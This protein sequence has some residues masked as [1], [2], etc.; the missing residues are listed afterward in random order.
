MRCLNISNHPLIVITFD[1]PI[2]I[3]AVR[4]VL[5]KN[6]PVLVRLGGFHLLKSYLGSIEYIMR[7]SGLED[8]LNEIYKSSIPNI[9]CG[10]AYYKCLRAHF[11]IDS[12]LTTFILESVI[13]EEDVVYIETYLTNISEDFLGSDEATER[14]TNISKKVDEKFTILSSSGRTS[15]FWAGYHRMICY[16][17][18]F[19]RSERLHDL[20]LHLSTVG[21]MLPIFAASGHG[22]YAKGSRL[23]LQLMQDFQK[24]HKSVYEMFEVFGYHTVRYNNKKWCG[25]WM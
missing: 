11:L 2:W 12:A 22:S 6:L 21:S 18:N 8:C 24:K 13:T 14:L 16:L 25:V 1:F 7:D 20:S 10:N 4:I 5:E 19:I 9:I 17:K 15:K 23:Y 3:K